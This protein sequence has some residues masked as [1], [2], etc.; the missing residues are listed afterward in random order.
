MLLE[1]AAPLQIGERI[2]L[3]I[4][5]AGPAEATIV[6]TSGHY[7]GCRF[8]QPLSTA[9]VSA[10]LLRSPDPGEEPGGSRAVYAALVELRALARVIESITDQVDR[11][12][13]ELT[14]RKTR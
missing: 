4:P 2:D 5:E 11:A 10:A 7:F 3:V 1:S 12:I 9:A 14:D 8:E 13:D 6:W